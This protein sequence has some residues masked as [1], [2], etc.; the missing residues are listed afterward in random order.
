MRSHW[1]ARED[2]APRLAL[3]PGCPAPRR[4]ELSQRLEVGR[5]DQGVRCPLHMEKGKLGIVDDLDVTR[6]HSL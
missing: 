6:V 4:E 3:W 5:I 2:A 1:T